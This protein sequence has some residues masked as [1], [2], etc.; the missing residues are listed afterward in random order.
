MKKTFLAAAAL[1]ILTLTAC[2]S[3]DLSQSELEEALGRDTPAGMDFDLSCDSGIDLEDGSST[4]CTVEYEGE[5]EHSTVTYDEENHR[6]DFSAGGRL[7]L[8]DIGIDRE[9]EG[10]GG[11][12]GGPFGN[13]GNNDDD[14]PEEDQSNGVGW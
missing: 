4:E 6:F 3:E 8:D 1:A 5:T 11:S 9:G 2:G 10:A 12:T 13:T 7:Y 14:E